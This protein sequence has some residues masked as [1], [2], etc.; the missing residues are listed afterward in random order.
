MSTSLSFRERS[1]ELLRLLKAS[2][3]QNRIYVDMLNTLNA[4]I[5]AA[6]LALS[7]V[8]LGSPDADS[9]SD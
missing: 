6:R 1:D 8:P 5:A 2:E 4:K 9:Q 7:S 3:R